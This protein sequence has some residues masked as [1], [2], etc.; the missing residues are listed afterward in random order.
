[1]TKRLYDVWT[2]KNIYSSMNN[3]PFGTKEKFE[4]YL[5]EYPDDYIAYPFYANV[6]LTLGYD[7]EC[8]EVID[9]V[10]KLIYSDKE[11]YS[12]K[13]NIKY[14][15]ENI[16][17]VELKKL[18]FYEDYDAVYKYIHDENNKELLA[19]FN[20]DQIEFLCMK[21]LDMIKSKSKYDKSY[22]L[23]QIIDYDYNDFLDHIEKHQAKYVMNTDSA[24]LST[25]NINFPMD[26]VLDEIHKY[27]PS[28]KKMFIGFI[29]DRYTFKYDGC[30][31][32]KGKLVN[33]F[34]VVVFHNTN[35]IITIYPSY[36][37]RT[38]TPCIDLNYI[39]DIVNKDNKKIKVR[40][41]ID[42]FNNR[43]NNRYNNR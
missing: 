35:N 23:R 7:K 9:Y 24:N 42:K 4:K 26:M 11:F 36:D 13:N 21:K 33:Y 16:A 1:M 34:D 38:N 32:V 14:V 30:G 40:S 17:F 12:N 19:D 43:Y 29:E 2:Q 39:S 41:Q 20:L 27:I 3:D 15:E 37:D 6:L 18:V 25:F 31:R 5:I 8:I 10:R 22:L 28:N